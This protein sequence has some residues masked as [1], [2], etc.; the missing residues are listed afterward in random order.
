MLDFQKASRK[1]CD[2]TSRRT[3]ACSTSRFFYDKMIVSVGSLVCGCIIDK[4]FELLTINSASKYY[5][6]PSRLGR[7]LLGL[8]QLLCCIGVTY[9]FFVYVYSS[10]P[11]FAH[12]TSTDIIFPAIFFSTQTTMFANFKL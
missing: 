11:V 9:L 6:Q 3:G 1:F 5:I 2:Y 12:S 8:L 10:K 4:V 7:V